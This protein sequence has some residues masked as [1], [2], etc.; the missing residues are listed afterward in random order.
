MSRSRYWFLSKS[1]TVSQL[2]SSI[3]QLEELFAQESEKMVSTNLMEVE[4]ENMISCPPH[5]VK[6][7]HAIKL[8]KLVDECIDNGEFISFPAEEG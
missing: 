3:E 8:L 6:L 5:F 7:I 4:G 1:S 2:R